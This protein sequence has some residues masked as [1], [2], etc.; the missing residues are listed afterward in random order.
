MKGWQNRYFVLDPNGCTLEY[1]EVSYT[2]MF[3]FAR[4]T[5]YHTTLPWPCE[6][7]QCDA[8]LQNK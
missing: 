2:D 3:A 5:W 6:D 8:W 4:T 1:F 7:G